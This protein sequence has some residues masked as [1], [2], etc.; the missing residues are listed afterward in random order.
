MAEM[1]GLPVTG[2]FLSLDFQGGQTWTFVTENQL[3]GLILPLKKGG[4]KVTRILP[5]RHAHLLPIVTKEQ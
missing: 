4:H 2:R 5:S 3:L 1:R